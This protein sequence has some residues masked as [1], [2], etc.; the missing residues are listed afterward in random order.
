M[1]L[2]DAEA[3]QTFLVAGKQLMHFTRQVLHVMH[4]PMAASWVSYHAANPL[5]PDCR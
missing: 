3:A 5:L 4:L 2:R 1:L